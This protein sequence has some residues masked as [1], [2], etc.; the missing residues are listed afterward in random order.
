MLG[1]LR[2]DWTRTAQRNEHIVVDEE[3]SVCGELPSA[4]AL[5]EDHNAHMKFRRLPLPEKRNLYQ[6]ISKYS[7]TLE[8]LFL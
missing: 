2:L 3:F 8:H 5:S 1:E 7:F 4:S 6:T